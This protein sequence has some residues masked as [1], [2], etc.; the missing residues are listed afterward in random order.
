[1]ADDDIAGL[2][3]EVRDF[4][5][6]LALAGGSD[7]LD[8]VR[9]LLDAAAGRLAPGGHLVLELG[10]GPGAGR[11]RNAVAAR[12]QLALVRFRRDLQG[13]A[14]TLVARRRAAPHLNA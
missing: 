3:P 2:P 1:M 8:V 5:P 13:I 4:E 14:R 9:R 6:R 10:S 12:P 11:S 7:G